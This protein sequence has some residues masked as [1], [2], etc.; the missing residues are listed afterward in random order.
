MLNEYENAIKY[1]KKVESL[2][3][4]YHIEQKLAC[5]YFKNKDTE[6]ALQQIYKGIV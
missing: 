4:A 1:F 5:A 2:N 6:N 3:P